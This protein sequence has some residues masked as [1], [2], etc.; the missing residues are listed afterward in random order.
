MPDTE[1]R[2]VHEHGGHRHRIIQKLDKEVLCPHEYL[3]VLLFSAIPRRN[4]NDIAHRLLAEFGSVENVLSAPVTRL[5]KVEG[6]GESVA[7]FLRTVGAILDKYYATQLCRYPKEFHYDSFTAFLK[8]EYENIANEVLDIYVIGE[9]GRITG[10]RRYD[11]SS[12]GSVS[13]H[14]KWLNSFFYENDPTGVVLVHTHPQGEAKPSDADDSTTAQIQTFCEQYGVVFCDHFIYSPKGV[15]S[16][17]LNGK[18][19]RVYEGY[20]QDKREWLDNFITGREK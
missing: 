20:K 19:K 9:T 14:V 18:M 7:G 12:S 1:T 10:R 3:E 16:Y 15:Y 13:I 11:S 17:A 8:T 2:K 4:T 6:V 5:Q